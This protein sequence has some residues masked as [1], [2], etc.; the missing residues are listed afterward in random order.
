MVFYLLHTDFDRI[1][2]AILIL[3]A[4]VSYYTYLS[5][6]ATPWSEI[7]PCNKICKPLVVYRFLGNVMASITTLRR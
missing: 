6:D 3:E 4:G 2:Q 1:D 7:M 5:Y